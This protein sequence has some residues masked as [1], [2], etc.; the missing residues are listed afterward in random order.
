M[1]KIGK[2]VGLSSRTVWRFLRGSQTED[3]R[4]EFLG[5]LEPP[6]ESKH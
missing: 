6:K 2:E 3:Y 4:G 5:K 1:V